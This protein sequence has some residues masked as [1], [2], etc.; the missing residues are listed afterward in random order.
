MEKPPQSEEKINQKY[1]K[2]YQS[3]PTWMG[4]KH[5]PNS[6]IFELIG[7]YRELKSK[8]LWKILFLKRKIERIRQ[9]SVPDHIPKINER[10]L[11]SDLVKAEIILE[12]IN[13][14]IK[15]LED[16]RTEFF[17]L[18][19]TYDQRMKISNVSELSDYKY[20]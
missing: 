7:D 14:Q 12:V 6:L 20:F 18:E 2:R 11:R 5:L 15:N 16:L 13:S 9:N 19:R 17:K 1:R 4:D 3:H 8:I 10:R